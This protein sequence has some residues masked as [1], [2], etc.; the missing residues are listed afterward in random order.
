M[1]GLLN[2]LTGGGLKS[3]SMDSAKERSS[4]AFDEGAAGAQKTQDLADAI[5]E[6]PRD[7]SVK[8]KIPK[9]HHG[10]NNPLKAFTSEGSVG[11]QF[12]PDGPAGAAADKVGG[13]FDKEGAIGK[14]FTDKGSIGGTVDK[15]LG[16]KK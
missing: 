15:M 14:Q 3:N 13:P 8:D 1:S 4:A 7:T 16:E 6:D 5:F 2:K 11:K 12:N 10:G 9:D